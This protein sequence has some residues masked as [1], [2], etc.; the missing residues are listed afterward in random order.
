MVFLLNDAK[1][2]SGNE[3]PLFDLFTPLALR[4]CDRIVVFSKDQQRE[5]KTTFH[6]DASVIHLVHLTHYEMYYQHHS[7]QRERW[8]ILFFG[9]VR[10]NKGLEILIRAAE[11][12][13]QTIPG[14]RVIIA[15]ECNV[16]DHYRNYIETPTMFEL[17]LGWIPDQNV[18][19]YFL[20]SQ[21]SILPYH[22][23]TQSGPLLISLSF[24]C[25]V[26]A[27]D[28]GGLPEYLSEGK[29]GLLF[30]KDSCSDLADKIVHLL[31]DEVRLR[32]MQ[33][34]SRSLLIDRFSPST[35]ATDLLSVLENI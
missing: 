27:A 31:T 26:I 18:G 13:R 7:I 32:D 29:N 8:T 33:S 30:K 17:H 11:I 2:H 24:N 34:N 25:P 12:A 4:F 10:P 23:A 16:F 1:P 35:I 28:V 9:T 15:G 6:R 3:E 5:C 22:D 19:R 21:C 20:R 14:L